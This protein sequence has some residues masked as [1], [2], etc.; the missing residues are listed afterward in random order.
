M[1]LLMICVTSLNKMTASLCDLIMRPGDPASEFDAGKTESVEALQHTKY[2]KQV[3]ECRLPLH[4]HTH[5]HT[6]TTRNN[7]V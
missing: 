1:S 2:I 3:C 4:T 7:V 5:T 6:Y